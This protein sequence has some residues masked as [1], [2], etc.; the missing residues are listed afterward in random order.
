M[1]QQRITGERIKLY[2][3][4]GITLIVALTIL[5]LAYFVMSRRRRYN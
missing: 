4:I 2:T 1:D 3:H 5:L